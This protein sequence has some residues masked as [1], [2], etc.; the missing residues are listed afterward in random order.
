MVFTSIQKAQVLIMNFILGS[1]TPRSQNKLFYIFLFQ[2]NNILVKKRDKEFTI[3]TSADILNWEIN[4]SNKFYIGSLDDLPCY[5]ARFPEDHVIPNDM[6]FI[7]LRVLNSQIDN[8]MLQAAFR[9]VQIISWDETHRFCGVCGKAT[10]TKADE[11]AKVCPACG[12]TSYPRL[13]P[14]VIVAV[15]KGDKLLLASN[16]NFTTTM[17]SVL[18]GFVEA[19]ETLE[20]CIKREVREEVGIEIK[21]IEYF[22]SQPWPFPNSL[23]IAF[24]AE[25][26]SGEIKIDEN[27][28][29][30]ARW[31][32]AHELP[33]IPGPLSISRSLIEWFIAKYKN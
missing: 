4:I 32:G 13:S 12:H 30:D 11:H 10:L 28:I 27:E 21:N 19:G 2:Q 17:Y 7:G 6:E 9:A 15:T 26:A 20:E 18:A 1:T 14:A 23:M 29:S 5:V 16:T 3:P 22:G 33:N 24:T 8:T 31:F 25:H